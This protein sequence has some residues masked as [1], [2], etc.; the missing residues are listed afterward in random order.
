MNQKSPKRH[1]IEF[2]EKM[3]PKK[4]KIRGGGGLLMPC[5][6]YPVYR[7]IFATQ[8]NVIYFYIGDPRYIKY[9]IKTTQIVNAA[10]FFLANP[11]R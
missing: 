11:Y 1:I 6:H 5:Q 3:D 9:A 7:A 2:Q 10:V 8:F 4:K